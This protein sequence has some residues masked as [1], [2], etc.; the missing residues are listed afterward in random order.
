MDDSRI[1]RDVNPFAECDRLDHGCGDTRGFRFGDDL[2][3]VQ[4][5]A[6]PAL[7]LEAP[8]ELPHRF[9]VGMGFVGALP[10]R[11]VCKEDKGRMSSYRHWI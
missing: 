9:R 6:E 8:P 10:G 3:I 2:D 4:E 11:T 1:G 7:A 5:Q